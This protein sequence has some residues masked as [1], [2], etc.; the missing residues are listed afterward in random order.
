MAEPEL[1]S[2]LFETGQLPPREGGGFVAYFT[3][4]N[5]VAPLCHSAGLEVEAVFGVEGLVSMIE[6]G[7]NALEEEAW[8]YWVDLNTRVAA[9]PSIHGVVEHLLAVCRKPLWRVVL[10]ALAQTLNEAGLDYRV[11]G[12]TSL[13]LRGLP[14]PSNDLDLEMP[15][16]DTYRFNALFA[17]D[18]LMPVAFREGDGVR[19]HFGRFMVGGVSVEVMGGLERLIGDRWVSSFC[20]TRDTVDLDDVPVAVLELEEETLA[21]IRRG[22]LDRAALALPHCDPARLLN[23]LCEALANGMF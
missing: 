14:V 16:E 12:G 3:H 9:D 23:L 21:C 13:A 4:P 15:P 7:I 1:Y 20:E 10:R 5:E 22:K 11:V 6:D 17:D 18:A 8:D 19:S 2:T